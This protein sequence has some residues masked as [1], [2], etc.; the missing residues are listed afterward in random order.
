MSAFAGAPS[1][2][3]CIIPRR[4][5]SHPQPAAATKAC[6]EWVVLLQIREHQPVSANPAAAA[7][8]ARRSSILP[9]GSVYHPQCEALRPAGTS[10]AIF[11]GGDFAD[12]TVDGGTAGLGDS[13]SSSSTAAAVDMDMESSTFRHQRRRRARRGRWAGQRAM[14]AAAAE[15]AARAGWRRRMKLDLLGPLRQLHA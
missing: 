11:C 12:V 14:V 13:S 1:A 10:G 5:R 3:S 7:V 15:L 2:A 4:W 6:G 8:R 9:A